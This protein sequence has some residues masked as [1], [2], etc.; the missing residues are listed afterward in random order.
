MVGRNGKLP[1]ALEADQKPFVDVS[2]GLMNVPKSVSELST[3]GIDFTV[4]GS[5][6]APRK[7]N[8][9]TGFKAGKKEGQRLSKISGKR[10][11]KILRS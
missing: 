3:S 10:A 4:G 7:K 8:G 5:V 2:S 11:S 1:K 9:R 6:K